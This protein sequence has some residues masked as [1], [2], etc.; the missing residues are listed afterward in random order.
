VKLSKLSFAVSLILIL[1]LAVLSANAQSGPSQMGAAYSSYVNYAYNGSTLSATLVL[2]GNTNP[3]ASATTEYHNGE[4]QVWI[5]QQI[6]QPGGSYTFVGGNNSPIVT[7][8]Q[9]S[10]PT[11]MSISTTAIY[12]GGGAVPHN[13][14]IKVEPSTK[15]KC[16]AIARLIPALAGVFW[17]WYNPSETRLADTYYQ[18]TGRQGGGTFPG[19]GT[20]SNCAVTAK[21]I[22]PP[23]CTID[24]G[25][26]VQGGSV[27]DNA[28][29]CSTLA[30]RATSS[31]P[32][33][34]VNE[35]SPVCI[36]WSGT[37]PN[38]CN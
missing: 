5:G 30:I 2:T 13:K 17:K 14:I 28:K 26:V 31:S 37:L 18:V 1:C 16:T 22:T 9:V 27:C 3:Y 19:G 8:G 4:V 29:L 38:Y 21:C 36:K 7:T 6:L 10:P 15:V 23:T 25:I 11:W 20:F 34:C 24:F 12:A 33:T 32:W 35:G